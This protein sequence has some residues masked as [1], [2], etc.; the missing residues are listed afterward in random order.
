MKARKRTTASWQ[1]ESERRKAVADRNVMIAVATVAE[2]AGDVVTMVV[3]AVTGVVLAVAA[4]DADVVLAAA[5]V[6][7]AATG[8]SY[9]HDR[10]GTE[11]FRAL[12]FFVN[13]FPMT[14]CL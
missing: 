12:C 2:I 8:N 9:Q 11:S 7:I 5:A 14:S 1:S 3:A 4:E 13:S 6:E 10:K